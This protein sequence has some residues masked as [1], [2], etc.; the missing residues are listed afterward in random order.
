MCRTCRCCSSND[1]SP[2]VNLF[3]TFDYEKVLYGKKLS[4][5]G[6]ILITFEHGKWLPI[7]SCTWK[8]QFLKMYEKLGIFA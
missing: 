8:Y 1:L 5:C 6:L 7:S 3:S 2:E 4:F